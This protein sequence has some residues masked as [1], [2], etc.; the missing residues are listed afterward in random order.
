MRKTLLTVLTL[1]CT[2][3]ITLGVGTACTSD[4]GNNSASSSAQV[5]TLK[6]TGRPT[7]DT[8]T[9]T[10]AENTLTLSCDESGV[11]WAS[12][13]TLVAT[14]NNGV[15]TLHAAGSTVISVKKGAKTDE[16]ILTVIDGR[17]P[18]LAT[19]TITGM[20]QNGEVQFINGGLQLSATCS[21]GGVVVW[22][23]NDETVATV[24]ETGKV[25]FVSP[26]SVDIVVQKE[27]ETSVYSV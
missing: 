25:T 23:S 3:A 1:L 21:D 17:I 27:G 14:V 9:L 20:P 2:F 7:D 22:R 16:F 19:I 18:E 11:T 6:I 26:G 24:D 8:V 15:V 10:D 4:G 13:D 5:E 12:S